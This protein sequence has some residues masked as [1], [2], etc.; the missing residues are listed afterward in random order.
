MADLGRSLERAA[1]V[2]GL[3]VLADRDDFVGSVAMRTR[4]ARRAG[5][6]IAHIANAGHRWMLDQPADTATLLNR[7]WQRN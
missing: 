5:A 6:T 1:E 3:V 4:A 2:P 7:F